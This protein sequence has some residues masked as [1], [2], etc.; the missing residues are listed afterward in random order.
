MSKYPR[1]CVAG[2]AVLAAMFLVSQAALAQNGG[3]VIPNYVGFLDH[4]GCDSFAGWAADWNRLNTAIPVH[5]YV[6]GQ[7]VTTTVANLSRPDVG[8]FLGDNGIHGFSLPAPW[9]LL[10]GHTHSVQVEFESSAVDLTHS[11]VSLFTCPAQ[12]PPVCADLLITVTPLQ[13][14]RYL[15][16]NRYCRDRNGRTRTDYGRFATIDD[17]VSQNTLVLDALSYTYTVASWTAY[18]GGTGYQSYGAAISADMASPGLTPPP[19]DPGGCPTGNQGWSVNA[20]PAPNAGGTISVEESVNVWAC[21]SLALPMYVEINDPSQ[22]KT[23]L[24]FNNIT[25]GDPDPQL[26]TI[27]PGYSQDSLLSLSPWGVPSCIP[28]TTLDPVIL[29]TR[30]LH[31]G[32]TVMTSIPNGYAGCSF[33][34]ATIFVGRS[35]SAVP[36][37]MKGLPIFQ[38]FLM[39]NGDPQYTDAVDFGRLILTAND[40]SISRSLIISLAI[41]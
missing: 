39:N 8:N 31:P 28:Q 30:N 13:G 7:L 19:R 12:L 22:G 32:R 38:L 34:D 25:V 35:L 20:H 24:E 17:V 21:P 14:T 16:T 27:P 9:V 6:D 23:E 2:I 40:G 3:P 11:P 36:L 29:V 18:G 15:R 41:E 37:T 1:H 26:F 10:D 5:I 4:A 33:V